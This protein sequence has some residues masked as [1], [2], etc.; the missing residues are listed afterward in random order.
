MSRFLLDTNVLL[1][2]AYG[3]DAQNSVASAAIITAVDPT[4]ITPV[5]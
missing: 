5:P 4:S 1:R 3:A 2:T